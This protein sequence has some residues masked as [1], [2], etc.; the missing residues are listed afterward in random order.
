MLKKFSGNNSHPHLISLLATFEQGSQCF[1]LFPWAEYDLLSFWDE[2]MP[3]PLMNR[4]L[5]LWVAEQCFGIASGLQTIHNYNPYGEN[6]LSA[7]TAEK[8][9]GR[10]GD[11]KPENILLFCNPEAAGA[12]LG[13]LQIADFGLT[14][15]NS[16]YSSSG[17]PNEGIRRTP[18]YRPPECDIVGGTIGRSWDIWT[19]GCLYLEFVT[20]L[21]GGNELLRQFGDERV[22]Q[23]IW[24]DN[25]ESDI[26]FEI[27][28][29][30]GTQAT[31]AMVKPQVVNVRHQTHEGHLVLRSLIVNK[32][33]I[34]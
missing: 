5:A 11:I 22:S 3:E 18:T 25:W 2:R 23:E 4:R 13:V 9:H 33:V 15:F 21:L 10:H 12:D 1:L 30:Q 19:L 31:A 6:L 17:I 14:V 29:P 8:T 32:S 27:V 20:W 34:Q 24:G 28:R 26:F 7:N 16:R